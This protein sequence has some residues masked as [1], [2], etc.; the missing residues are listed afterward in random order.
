MQISLP[1]RQQ[2]IALMYY[3]SPRPG[4]ALVSVLSLRLFL[5]YLLSFFVCGCI[6]TRVCGFSRSERVPGNI[7]GFCTNFTHLLM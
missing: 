5:L 6:S 1:S 4:A 2:E 7:C 3:L